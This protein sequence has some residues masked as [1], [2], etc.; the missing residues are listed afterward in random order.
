MLQNSFSLEIQE[1]FLK[2]PKQ[3]KH[4]RPLAESKY[5]Y[6]RFKFWKKNQI[7]KIK[8]PYMS[9]LFNELTY[10]IHK[11]W[12]KSKENYFDFE[13]L[14]GENRFTGCEGIIWNTKENPYIVTWDEYEKAK[15]EEEKEI[16]K[17]GIFIYIYI[18]I[19]DDRK[20][21]LLLHT[22]MKDMRL[23]MTKFEKHRYDEDYHDELANAIMNFPETDEKTVYIIEDY[24]NKNFYNSTINNEGSV[25][26]FATFI[27][28]ELRRRFG[29]NFLHDHDEKL[30]MCSKDNETYYRYP[31]LTFTNTL[32]V[33]FEGKDHLPSG[34]LQNM[35]QLWGFSQR[36]KSNVEFGIV[37]NLRDWV[38]TKFTFA[39]HKFQEKHVCM[40]TN[41]DYGPSRNNIQ[42]LVMFLAAQLKLAQENSLNYPVIIPMK[43]ED[44]DLPTHS[45]EE[46]SRVEAKIEDKEKRSRSR[47]RD[48]KRSTHKRD[49]DKDPSRYHNRFEFYTK[50]IRKTEGSR[51]SGHKEKH[52]KG[53]YI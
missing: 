35:E 33:E 24:F 21:D 10:E 18:Y 44:Q 6:F 50:Y 26:Y 43:D 5:I 9:E 4:P 48:K 49:K 16:G 15:T 17:I 8:V 29:M 7:D 39:P 40:F 12:V 38:L 52:R 20:F 22:T 34:I 47:S 13:Y 42:N 11:R 28:M 27:L 32:L 3:P 53:Y 25:T 23:N 1:E 19:E 51:K 30:T 36:R 37:T 45:K 2:Q 41:A 46:K 14:T 31:D